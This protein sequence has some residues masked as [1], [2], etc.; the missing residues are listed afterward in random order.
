MI[1]DNAVRFIAFLLG[2]FGLI[3]G[4]AKLVFPMKIKEFVSKAPTFKFYAV[5]GCTNLVIASLFIY[6]ST[7]GK[8]VDIMGYA[9]IVA[10]TVVA[11]VGVAEMIFAPKF[12]DWLVGGSIL[13]VRVSACIGLVL[14]L[15][16]IYL[17]V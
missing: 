1:V 10:A 6:L 5:S 9:A 8:I 7:Q 2:I 14:S 11:V 17:A 4:F 15:L 3:N 12:K 16:L 13:Y